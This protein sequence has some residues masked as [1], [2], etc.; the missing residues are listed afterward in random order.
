MVDDLDSRSRAPDAC[1]P[2]T[3]TRDGPLL[4]FASGASER[5]VVSSEAAYD[6]A[7]EI[8]DFRRHCSGHGIPGNHGQRNRLAQRERKLVFWRRFGGGCFRKFWSYHECRAIG[9]WWSHG[10]GKGS[11]GLNSASG[12]SSLFPL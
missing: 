2:N 9:G 5:G 8:Q 10:L 6:A 7:G 3:S 12:F 11:R 1:F 4:S